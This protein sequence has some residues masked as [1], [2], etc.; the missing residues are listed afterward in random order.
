MTTTELDQICNDL[1]RTLLNTD[2]ALHFPRAI[3][4]SITDIRITFANIRTLLLR[5]CND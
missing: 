5:C 3:E 4:N 1:C 2:A